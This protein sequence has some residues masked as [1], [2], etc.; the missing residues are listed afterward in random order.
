MRVILVVLMILCSAA[1][2][3][4]HDQK[5]DRLV[6][7]KWH[8][9]S[10]QADSNIVGGKVSYE[11][12]LELGLETGDK[13]TGKARTKVTLDGKSYTVARNVTGKL[14]RAKN[15]IEIEMVKIRG[16]QLPNR[17]YWCST[18][19]G[20]LTFFQNK[21]RPLKH[22]LKGTLSSGGCGH[23]SEFELRD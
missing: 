21:D 3:E 19:S 17:R 6:A 20:T 12:W 1:V 9:V 8:G 23:D 7:I 14:D 11:E 16:D 2:A 22:L 4:T 13:L 10:Q 5:L 18:L 15:A